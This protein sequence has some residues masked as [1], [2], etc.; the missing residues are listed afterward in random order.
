MIRQ[1]YLLKAILLCM[2]A[3]SCSDS[4]SHTAVADAQAEA[5]I[6]DCNDKVCG[7]DGCGGICGVCQ[8]FENCPPPYSKCFTGACLWGFTANCCVG[9][10][11]LKCSGGIFYEQ[12]CR[13]FLHCGWNSEFKRY[14]CN[15][16]GSEDP[17]G[18]YPK[19]CD[20]R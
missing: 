9:E 3:T 19:S 14:L 6:P 8:P 10:L 7:P 2:G 16:T 5:C 11:L 17:S 20:D 18:K 12:D 15:T 4:G 1:F 13:G